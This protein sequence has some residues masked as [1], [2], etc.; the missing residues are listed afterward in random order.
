MKPDK[1]FVQLLLCALHLRNEIPFGFSLKLQISNNYKEIRRNLFW[2]G[3]ESSGEEKKVQ[4]NKI[5]CCGRHI[6]SALKRNFLIP[7]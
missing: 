1:E 3:K 2:Q 6:L 5:S 4:E 7:N